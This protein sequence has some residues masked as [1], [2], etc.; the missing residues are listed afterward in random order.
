MFKFL[1]K[2]LLV[3]LGVSLALLNTCSLSLYDPSSGI[4]KL[5]KDNF[6]SLVLDQPDQLWFINY[7]SPDCEMS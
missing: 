4:V 7:Y 6:K 3:A 1:D 2:T 5:T